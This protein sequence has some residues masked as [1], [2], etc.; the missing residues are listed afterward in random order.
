LISL[1]SILNTDWTD[2]LKVNPAFVDFKIIQPGYPEL[3]HFNMNVIDFAAM[4]TLKMSVQR[5]IG[6]IPISFSSR[7]SILIIPLSTNKFSVLYNVVF[8]SVG[9]SSNSSR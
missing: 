9:I 8:D 4:G 3:G 6:I 2:A 7:L 5:N 1:V